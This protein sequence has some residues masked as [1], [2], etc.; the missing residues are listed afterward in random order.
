MLIKTVDSCF[1]RPSYQKLLNVSK[2]FH[3]ILFIATFIQNRKN[4]EYITCRPTRVAGLRDPH[5][6]E[7]YDKKH[8]EA[9][10][11]YD[12]HDDKQVTNG[13]TQDEIPSFGDDTS[14]RNRYKVLIS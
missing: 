10:D 9:R 6:W 11:L 5:I 14:Q 4:V 2:V 7:L 12:Q 8:V 1:L 13:D 3:K